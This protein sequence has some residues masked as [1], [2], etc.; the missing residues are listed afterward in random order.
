MIENRDGKE[1]FW[2]SELELDPFRKDALNELG[3]IASCHAVTALA[4]MT[5]M[6]INIAVPSVDIVSITDTEKLLE[7]EKIVAGNFIRL[8]G[9]FS[10]YLQVLFPERSALRL[11]DVLMCRGSGETKSIETEMEESAL[12]ETGNILA[13]AFCSAIADFFQFSMLPSPPSFALDM[14]GAMI[15]SAIIAVAQAHETEHV[16]LFKCD[17]EEEENG[18]YGYI[19]LFP[20]AESLNNI[21]SMLEA[22][23]AAV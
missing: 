3:N 14:M 22:T 6:T 13:S 12:M 1:K 2:D 7:L 18:L 21:L 17:F 4:E 9:G 11:V 15:E 8:E 10:G 19:L 5:G 20:N 23:V 16:V